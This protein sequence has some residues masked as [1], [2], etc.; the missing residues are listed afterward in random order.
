NGG[1]AVKGWDQGQILVRAQIQTGAPNAGEAVQLA[2]QVQIET[3]GGKIYANG[4]E[5]QR[6]YHWSVNY[7]VFVPRR[8]NLSIET[9]NGGIAI[10]EVNGRIDFSALNGGVVLKRCGG[11]VHGSTTNGGLVVELAGDRWDGETLD[12]RTTNGGV[13]MSVPENYSAQL[14]TGTV[15]GSISVDFP[16]TVQGRITKELAVNL[17]SGGAMVRAMTTNGGVRI[18]RTSMN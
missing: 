18:K 8:S 6:D 14:Q 10:S 1:V 12:V 5:N 17:G 4:P 2:R 3:S 9:H 7:E 11:S 15:N 16:V 13:S